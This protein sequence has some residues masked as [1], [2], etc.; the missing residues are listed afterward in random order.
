MEMFAVQ[1]LYDRYGQ[2]IYARAAADPAF[3]AAISEEVAGLRELDDSEPRLSKLLAGK[4]GKAALNSYLLGHTH[5]ILACLLEAAVRPDARTPAAGDPDFAAVRLGALFHLAFD[6]G[7]LQLHR[8]DA[9]RSA[10]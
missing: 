9:P 7:L 8:G 6:G 2:E 4:R 1:R 5:A 10:R 3:S